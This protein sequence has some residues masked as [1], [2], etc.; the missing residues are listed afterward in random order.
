VRPVTLKKVRPRSTRNTCLLLAAQRS[1]SF[2]KF[3][4]FEN[5]HQHVY[6]ALADGDSAPATTLLCR[7]EKKMREVV[8]ESVVVIAFEAPAEVDQRRVVPCQEM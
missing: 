4:E 8:P 7:V 2:H 1:K 3:T 5:Y 6:K